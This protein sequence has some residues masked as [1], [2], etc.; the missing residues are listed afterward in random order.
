MAYYNRGNSRKI[1]FGEDGNA[2]VGLITVNL[3]VFVLLS[4]IKVIYYFNYGA[5]GIVQYKADVLYYLTLPASLPVFLTRPWTLITHFITHD[6]VWHILPNMLW[7][8]A[9]GFIMQDLT[10]N[11]RIVPV[12]I[13]GALGGAVAFMLAF[14]LIPAMRDSL[15]QAVAL[16]ASAGVMAIAIATTMIAPDYRLFPMIL[17]GIPLWVLTVIFAVIDL[18]TI[19][20]NN[21]GGHIAH[22]AGALMG[23]IFMKEL[24][25]GRDWGGWMTSFHY[26]FVNLFNPDKPA[27]GKAVKDQLFYKARVAPFNRRTNITQQRVDEILEKIHNKGFDSL[28]EEEKEILKKA[29]E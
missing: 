4:F 2:L 19:P 7:L 15:P 10:G 26:W 23:F 8:W 9:F 24:G 28:T 13:Y 11:R 25:K 12:F 18:A 27:K 6:D 16:G 17:G 3:V 29:G 20:Y 21:A 1:S 14:N 5:D 22:L